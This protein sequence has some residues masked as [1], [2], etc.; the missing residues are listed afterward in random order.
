MC[1]AILVLLCLTMVSKEN[2]GSKQDK[3]TYA[4]IMLLMRFE[5]ASTYVTSPSGELS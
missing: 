4:A 2:Y 1:A 3:I 5:L